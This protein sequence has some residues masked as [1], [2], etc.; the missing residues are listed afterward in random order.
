MNPE[1]IKKDWESRGHCFGIFKDPPGQIWSNF[2]QKTDEIVVLAQGEIEI[3]IE[4]K[5]K[6]QQPPIGKE[7]FIHV[8]AIHTVRNI[9]NRNNVW[10][11]GYKEISVVSL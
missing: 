11:Y 8:I 3:E 1:Q 10:Y 2:V 7:V 6:S 9:G 4:I 5:G